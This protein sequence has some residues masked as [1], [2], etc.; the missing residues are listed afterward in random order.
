M[1][2]TTFNT[3]ESKMVIDFGGGYQIV[4]DRKTEM[5]YKTKDGETKETFSTAGM[6]LETFAQIVENFEKSL[7]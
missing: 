2:T 3:S 1:R 5:A 4:Y 6:L 7:L